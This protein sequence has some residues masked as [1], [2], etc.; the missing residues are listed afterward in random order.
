[1]NDELLKQA[2]S[3]NY[4]EE[5][6]ERIR[7]IRSSEKVFWR[8]VLD[9]YATSLDYDSKSESSM[10]FF[11]TVQNKMHWAVHGNTAAELVYQRANSAQTNMG[12]TNFKGTKPTQQEAQTAKNYLNEDELKLL[13]RMVTAYIELA[14]IQAMSQTPMYMADWIARLDDFLKITGKDILAHA[15]KISHEK[16]ME[17]ASKEYLSYKEQTKNELSKVEEDYIEHLDVM[18]KM[19]KGK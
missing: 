6:L 5:L 19:L 13:N 7:D 15:G 10:L 9:I 17:K 8:K 14:E 4:F 2:G 16:A 11:Q 12:L 18:A 1:M 3:G